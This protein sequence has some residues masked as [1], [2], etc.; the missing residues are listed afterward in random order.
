MKA[1]K[2]IPKPKNRRLLRQRLGVAYFRLRRH[3]LNADNR[4]LSVGALPDLHYEHFSHQTPLLRKLKDVDM[5][6]QHNKIINL[7]I[8]IQQLTGVV[9]EPGQTLSYWQQIGKPTSKRGYVK[10]MLLKQGKVTEG[11]GGGLC[12]LSNL[13]YWMTLHTPLTVTERHRHSF[14]VFP[15]AG[16]TQ[17]FG[18]GA[19]CFYN[20]ID[21]R[22]KNETSQYFWLELELSENYLKGK[23]IS[24]A[25]PLFRYEIYEN[26]H[27]IQSQ[28]WGGYTRH[29][30]LY[31]RIFFGD[32]LIDNHLVTQ[33]HAIMMYN[34][35]LPSST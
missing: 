13:I 26:D 5:Y 33:N 22:I 20:Y 23:W 28:P 2:A 8:A 14:D 3:M 19:T 25:P 6:L 10:G 17:P 9:I 32:D 15:D 21:L 27:I 11:I 30:S 18:S 1:S 31:R 24:D 16:R 12:Q 29:N 7:S 35:L 4:P 34:P